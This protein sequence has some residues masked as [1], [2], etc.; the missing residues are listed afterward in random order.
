MPEVSQTTQAHCW[1][2]KNVAPPWIAG[3]GG[4]TDRI[5]LLFKENTFSPLSVA[6]DREGSGK[7]GSVRALRMTPSLAQISKDVDSFINKGEELPEVIQ[8]LMKGR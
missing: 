5:F 3:I 7:K 8:I 2:L 4:N 1:K 6:S